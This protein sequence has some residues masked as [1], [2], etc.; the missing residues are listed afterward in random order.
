[1][2]VKEDSE[3]ISDDGEFDEMQNFEYLNEEDDQFVMCKYD[4][5]LA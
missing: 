2:E 1:M 4:E 5:L 3:D